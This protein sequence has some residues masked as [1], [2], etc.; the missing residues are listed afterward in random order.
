MKLSK[1]ALE[2]LHAD[3]FPPKPAELYKLFKKVEEL[4]VFARIERRLPDSSSMR[5]TRSGKYEYRLATDFKLLVREKYKLRP[6]RRAI[7]EFTKNDQDE[8]I[9]YITDQLA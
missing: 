9:T 2:R 5:L 8:L 3:V 7:L 1:K 6:L 4:I